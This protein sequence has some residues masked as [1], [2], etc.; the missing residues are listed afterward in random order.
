MIRV[1]LLTEGGI[2]EAL[3]P[4]LL[5]QSAAT[6]PALR[7]LAI[8]WKAFPFA[9]N[10]YGEIPKNLKMLV[11]LHSRQS[12]WE[13]IGCDLFVVVHDSRKTDQV[14]GEIRAVLARSTTF[15]I[16]YGLA[17]QEVEAWVLGDIDNVN[18]YVFKIHPMP[19]LPFAPERDRDPKK[20]L[21]DLFVSRTRELEFDRWNVECAR[22]AAPFLRASQVQRKCPRGFGGLVRSLGRISLNESGR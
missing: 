6:I 1:G 7:N 14:Q 18:R 11:K 17:I 12:E 3:L 2:D 22:L 15:P 4:P 9:P 13:R 20:T 5:G 16:V 21:T 8:D 19:S 10:G